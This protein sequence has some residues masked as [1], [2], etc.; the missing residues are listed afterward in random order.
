LRPVDPAP[1]AKGADLRRAYHERTA[2]LVKANQRIKR[3]R[4]YIRD[5][6]AAPKNPGSGGGKSVKR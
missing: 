3:G 1:L 4:T 6:C 5:A 2:E